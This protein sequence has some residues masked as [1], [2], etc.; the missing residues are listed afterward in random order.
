[1]K[2]RI[3]G[4]CAVA[5][6]V[7][8]CG[9]GRNAPDEFAVG[10]QAPLVIPPDYGLTPPKPGSPRPLAADSQTQAMEALFGQGVRLPPKSP[11]EQELIDKAGGGKT[12]PTARSTVGDPDTVVVDKGTMVK[13]ILAAPASATDPAVA[14]VSIGG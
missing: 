8:A 12:D 14:Q 11:A 4:V 7:A 1:M 2:L 10:R 3:L 13:D 9:G 5:L 6:T